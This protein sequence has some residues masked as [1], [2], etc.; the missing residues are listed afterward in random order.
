VNL[1]R[2][3]LLLLIAASVTGCKLRIIVPEGGHVNN[4][5]GT[6]Y[7][8]TGHTCTASVVDI[9]FTD[10]FIAVPDSG[11][12]FKEWKKVDFGF[13][14]GSSEPCPLTTAQFGPY[15]ALMKILESDQVFYL[16]PVFERTGASATS[17]SVYAGSSVYCAEGRSPTCTVTREQGYQITRGMTYSEVVDFLGCHGELQ[18]WNDTTGIG[19]YHWGQPPTGALVG[20]TFE[21]FRCTRPTEPKVWSTAIVGG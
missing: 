1:F 20:V 21:C 5:A 18:T 2:A 16:Q 4:E 13:C 11:Y 14:G 10:T 9:Y 17:C 3:L 8:P 6:G 12:K 15:D 7:C 19:I